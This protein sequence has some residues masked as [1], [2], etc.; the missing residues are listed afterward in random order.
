MFIKQYLSEMNNSYDNHDLSRITVKLGYLD[1]AINISLSFLVNPL[2]D[3]PLY[4]LD[5]KLYCK[6]L[7]ASFYCVCS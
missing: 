6:Q 5:R 7:E 4:N 1:V 3:I 2:L